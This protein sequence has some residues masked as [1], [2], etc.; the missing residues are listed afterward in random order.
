M[1]K[2]AI[3][4]GG[5]S[6]EHDISI[7][8]AFLVM[9]NCKKTHRPFLM[10]YISRNGKF[11]AGKALHKKENYQKLNGFH[12]GYFYHSH[13]KHYFATK[14]RKY[15]IDAVILCVHGEGAEDGTVGA[16]FD[17]LQIPSSFSGVENA[18][19]MQNKYFTKLILKTLDIP[20]VNGILINKDHLSRN[21]FSLDNI[22][23]PFK[24]PYILKPV[25]LGSSI[26][27]YK[28]LDKDEIKKHLPSLFRLDNAVMIEET[29]GSL[30]EYNIAI[31][32]DGR[33][34]WV[35][36]IEEVNKD[37][38]VL[39]FKDKYEEFSGQNKRVIPASIDEEL[40]TQIQDYAKR[41]YKGLSCNGVVRF[42]FFYD[43]HNHQLYLN[44]INT[45]PGSLAYYLFESSG[46]SFKELLDHLVDSAFYHIENRKNRITVYKDSD[47]M[48]IM[49]KK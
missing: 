7:V 2:I 32:S 46:M 11:Y 13:K 49:H 12:Q 9:E 48:K 21:L 4:Y 19:V 15:K 33:Q 23:S 18:A 31:L 5:D 8:T 42:D 26:G 37:D 16:L 27:V 38:H 47:L 20:Y 30:H 22:L 14:T 43:E 24:P 25:H 36:D 39:S 28:C 6:L 41:A 45:V 29:I 35:S 34:I 10:V 1:K 40:K 17:C 44:E 3:V